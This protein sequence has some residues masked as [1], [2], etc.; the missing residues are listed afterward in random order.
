VIRRIGL[1]VFLLLVAAAIVVWMAGRG[2][3]GSPDGAGEIRGAARPAEVQRQSTEAV[4]SAAETIGVVKPKQILFGDFHVHTTLSFDAFMMSLPA[5]G[6]EGAHPPADACD[7]ARYCSALDFWSINDHA[8]A[9][10]PEAW[11]ATVESIRACNERAGDTA[12]PDSVA[13]LGWEWTQVGGT[14]DTHYGHKN[15]VLRGIG[16]DDVPAR[17]IPAAGRVLDIRMNPAPVFGRGL[18]ALLGGQRARDLAAYLQAISGFEYCPE[19]VNT[20]DLPRDCVEVAPTPDVLFRKLD[21]WGFDSI[22]IPHG[23]TWGFYTPAG[24]TWDKQL[25]GALHDE[26]RQTLLE[27]YSGHGDSE[28]YRSWRAVVKEPDGSVRCPEPTREYEPTCYRAGE[29]IRERCLAEGTD[30]DECDGRA[31]K[32]R[33]LAAEAGGQ[34]HLVVPG[35]RPAEWLDAGQCRDC[36][37]PAFN[38]R[39]GGSAQ[40]IAALGNFDEDPE[41]PRR[42]RLGFISSSDNHTA[43]PGTGYTETHRPSM[44]ESQPRRRDAP[45][46]LRRMTQAPDEDPAAEPIAFDP[47][48]TKLSGFQLVELERQGSFF[49]T[50]GLV[51][52]HASGRD[53]D[54]IWNSL[55]RREVYGTSGPRILLWFDLLNPPGSRGQTLPM[56][57]EVEMGAAP[58]FQVRAVGSF[59]QAGGCPDYAVD[60]LGPESIERLCRGVCYNP[61]DQR[62]R[63]SRIEVV[64]IRPQVVPDED[65][66]TLVDDPWRVLECDGSPEGCVATFSDPEFA[67]VGRD[68]LYY[69]RVFEEPAM[70]INAAGANCEYDA[71]GNCLRARLCEGEGDCLAENEPRAWSSPIWVDY[72]PEAPNAGPAAD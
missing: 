41:N 19:G 50:G 16:E 49:L 12:N 39:P 14:P 45:G 28:V 20:R 67:R 59:E 48:N 6:G 23:T 64:R 7:F 38:Y 60:A 10:S 2:M 55:Q 35:E 72:A 47:E 18:F 68:T 24:S 1:V 37:E 61:S 5:A 65:V 56:G 27:I 70:A 44:T 22:V 31:A 30:A 13:F 58:I 17:P 4:R 43:R 51:A 42:F 32:T 36:R 66:A 52:V 25:R 69:A 3:F 26:D 71:E 40:Y 46:L 15:V 21:E 34:A 29:I 57:G 8:E 9:I 33:Q 62:R 53:R 54:S 63:I 11:D